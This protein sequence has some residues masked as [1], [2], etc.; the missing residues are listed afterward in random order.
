MPEGNDPQQPPKYNL[1][2]L[3]NVGEIRQQ[4]GSLLADSF[5]DMEI[6]GVAAFK[7]ITEAAKGLQE[8]L[9]KKGFDKLVTETKRAVGAMDKTQRQFDKKRMT[10]EAFSFKQLVKQKDD[11]LKK[12]T[13]VHTK[14]LQ[15]LKKTIA[16]K[17]KLAAA[18]TK[19]SKEQAK[20]IKDF[21]LEME[22]EILKAKIAAGKGSALDKAK[23]QMND[24][25]GAARE[26]KKTIL[27]TKTWWEAL[28]FVMAQAAG[29]S[30]EM[31]KSQAAMR[32]AGAGGGGRVTGELVP[33]AAAGALTDVAVGA[34]GDLRTSLNLTAQDM[35]GLVQTFATAPKL[36][37]ELTSIGGESA[38]TF[39][40]GMGR[41]GITLE[42]SS[43][44]ASHASNVLGMSFEDLGKTMADSEAITNTTGINFRDVFQSMLSLQGSMRGLSFDADNARNVLVATVAPLKE[45]G[46]EN[47][48]IRKF[49]E[50]IGQVL[51]AMSPQKLAGMIAFTTGRAPTGKQGREDL[52]KAA[53]G[54]VSTLVDFLKPVLDNFETDSAER[55]FATQKLMESI[56]MTG[57]SNM[58]QVAAMEKVVDDFAKNPKE[59]KKAFE[60]AFG[61]PADIFKD[62]SQIQKEG[63]EA[64]VKM[65]HPLENLVKALQGFADELAGPGAGVFGNINALIP[66]LRTAFAPARL[67]NQAKESFNSDTDWKAI[68]TREM[69]E[70]FTEALKKHT[71]TG[72]AGQLAKRLTGG[73]K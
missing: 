69:V 3:F 22:K 36:I 28:L 14:E 6:A 46:F 52:L 32:A 53:K 64:L 42:E 73:S 24:L 39:M 68:A 70:G 16:D 47:A 10:A 50:G 5:K 56:N 33:G 27:D 21:K 29:Q 2:D 48:E 62:A 67:I 25:V 38:E 44:I 8:I 1:E 30:A 9:G 35:S 34:L 43:Q 55:L 19:K 23:N 17:Q 72:Q 31:A 59:A 15:D 51:G 26:Y 20:E 49:A 12:I 54:D 13:A 65:T 11:I 4:L 37:K 60:K 58:T 61:K 66:V 41:F 45:M 40:K 63:T 57:A 18:E 71:L 7:N